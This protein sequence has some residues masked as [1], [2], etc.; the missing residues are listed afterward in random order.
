MSTLDR[1][2]ALLWLLLLP[3]VCG[4]GKVAAARQA[5]FHTESSGPI[6]IHIRPQVLHT[7]VKRMGINLSGQSFYDSGQMLRNL[8]FRNPG[9]EGETW[10]SIL[11][12]K[13]VTRTSCTDTN[14]YAQWPAGFLDGATYEVISGVAHGH[15][16]VVQHST[17]AAGDQG[18]SLEFRDAPAHLAAGDFVLVRIDKPGDAQAGWWTDLKGGATLATET[19]DL[20]PH[21]PG[22]Q[23]LRIEASGAGQ[24]A[25]VS[26]FFDS[27]AGR[28]F[29]QLHGRYTL[30]FRAQSA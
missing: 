12:C 22:R 19:H 15:S 7:G 9:F 29:V 25:V 20:S 28:S 3:A 23:A 2:W 4:C 14:Q 16:G 11:R 13:V 8:T 10:Q 5:N 27:F 30:S 24:S 1:R 17:A 21:T 18:V 6:A 26:S